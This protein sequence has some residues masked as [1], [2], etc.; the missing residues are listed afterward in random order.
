MGLGCLM[1]FDGSMVLMV[2][3]GLGMFNGGSCRV[4]SGGR[5]AGGVG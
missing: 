2:F 1:V 5:W 4:I 3:G